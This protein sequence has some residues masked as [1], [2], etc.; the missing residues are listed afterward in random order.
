MTARLFCDMEKSIVWIVLRPVRVFGNATSASSWRLC[1]QRILNNWHYSTRNIWFLMT[2]VHCVCGRRQNV[3][4]SR[5]YACIIVVQALAPCGVCT[6][7]L[8]LRGFSRQLPPTDQTT[9]GW[10]Q[11]QIWPE[12]CANGVCARGGAQ[13]CSVYNPDDRQVPAPPTSSD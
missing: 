10:L 9:L 4:L 7:S 3:Q 12:V 8:F 1:N 13:T 6:F 11:S 2:D 5:I